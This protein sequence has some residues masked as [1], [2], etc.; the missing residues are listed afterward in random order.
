[1][2]KIYYHIT[3]GGYDYLNNVGVIELYQDEFDEDILK[4]ILSNY[5]GEEINNYSINTNGEMYDIIVINEN[6]DKT[7][8][9]AKQTWL[10][11]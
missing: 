1:M 8:F 9:E 6:G 5:L 3:E 10:Y 7:Y 2:S 11:I 4:T